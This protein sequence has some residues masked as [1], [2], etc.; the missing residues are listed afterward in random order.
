MYTR[1]S[2][3]L[4][5]HCSSSHS[6]I[7]VHNVCIHF[8]FLHSLEAII[9]FLLFLRYIYIYPLQLYVHGLLVFTS[10]YLIYI[11]LVLLFVFVYINVSYIF[12]YCLNRLCVLSIPCL[13]PGCVYC[14]IN[15]SSLVSL[16]FVPSQPL[17]WSQSLKIIIFL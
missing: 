8:F 11:L 9:L 15:P 10:C 14:S 16:V 7:W 17:F 4:L 5:L 3:Q 13:V 6:L 2:C 1:L 12:V